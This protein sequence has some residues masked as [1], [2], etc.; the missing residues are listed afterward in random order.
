MI[1]EKGALYNEPI[2][3]TLQKEFLSILQRNVLDGNVN[4]F[5]WGIPDFVLVNSSCWKLQFIKSRRRGE[6][7]KR[8]IDKEKHKIYERKA[9]N[10]VF[11]FFWRFWKEF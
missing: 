10:V 11:V 5:P 1:L 4:N 2:Y 9:T 6:H 7:E 8:E 3:Y